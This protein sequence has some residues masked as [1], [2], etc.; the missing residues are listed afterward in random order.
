VQ[1]GK[2]ENHVT[3]TSTTSDLAHLVCSAR[4]LRRESGHIGALCRSAVAA[5]KIDHPDRW[6]T[7]AGARAG[8]GAG[9]WDLDLLFHLLSSLLEHALER[10]A[11]NAPVSL[12][13]RSAGANVVVEVEYETEDDGPGRDEA[14]G[15][16]PS[17]ARR[18]ARAHGGEAAVART[19]WGGVRWT[20][21]LPRDARERSAFVFHAFTPC[22]ARCAK[23]VGT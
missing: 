9:C 11:P 5:A 15:G 12:R 16:G 22:L 10:G 19:C 7:G 17:I 14:L 13:W 20:V 18:I 1:Q 8:D 2:E 3:V 6:I 4:G 21:R 23:E